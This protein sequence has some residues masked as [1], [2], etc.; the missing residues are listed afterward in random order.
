VSEAELEE[1][2]KLGATPALTMGEGHEAT[3][4]L[5]GDYRE[6]ATPLATPMRTP[7]TAPGEDVIMQEARNLAALRRY[8]RGL[9]GPRGAAWCSPRE[10]MMRD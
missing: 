6:R 1:I 2:V 4:A 7:R 9:E 3:A 10:M 8:V 5:L